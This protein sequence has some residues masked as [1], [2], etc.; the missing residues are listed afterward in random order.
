MVYGTAPCRRRSRHNQSIRRRSARSGGFG[1]KSRNEH[2]RSATGNLI[3][4]DWDA[5][6][7]VEMNCFLCHL[8]TPNNDARTEAL[9]SGAFG[10]ANSA[11]LLGTGIIERVGDEWQWNEAAFGDDGKLLSDYVTV[12]DPSDTNCAQCHGLVHTDSQTPLVL[13]GCEPTQWSTITTGQ[14]QSAQKLSNSGMNLSD[15]DDLSRS[16]D[17]R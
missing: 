13:E 4:W 6:G 10:W 2:R 5:S 12:R 16:W 15:K 7:T 14:I 1:R 3:P 9:Q 17:A 11:T 8:D